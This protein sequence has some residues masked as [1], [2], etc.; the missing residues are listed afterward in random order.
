MSRVK[1]KVNNQLENE[2]YQLRQQVEE[3]RAALFEERKV[4]ERLSRDHASSIHQISLLEASLAQQQ[5]K[6]REEMAQ[7]QAGIVRDLDALTEEVAVVDRKRKELLVELAAFDVL[8]HERTTLTARFAGVKESLKK[9]NEENATMTERFAQELVGKR[10]KLEAVLRKTLIELKGEY[11]Q[12]TTA[13]MLAEA[14]RAK[15][16]IIDLQRGHRALT[17]I[18]QG[19]MATQCSSADQLKGLAIE[20][21]VMEDTLKLHTKRVRAVQRLLANQE[22]RLRSARWECSTAVRELADLESLTEDL[23]AQAATLTQMRRKCET[24]RLKTVALRR[25]AWGLTRCICQG[26]LPDT[27]KRS[28]SLPGLLQ[29]IHTKSNGHME[30]T[31]G[32]AEDATYYNK[33][34]SKRRTSHPGII[35]EDNHQLQDH[36]QLE[37]GDI[38]TGDEDMIWR[39][40]RAPL[41]SRGIGTYYQ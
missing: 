36:I 1:G 4:R 26:R 37:D 33:Y 19:V 39:A 13:R 29:T 11:E 35:L 9:I 20:V 14:M 21:P 30:V 28:S 23:L 6:Y 15:D 31:T 16:E 32:G 7:L 34:R 40:S 18:A 22:A 38:D 3:K 5:K 2:K 24:S 25:E 27:T 17:T 12:Q 8:E 41:P 10:T